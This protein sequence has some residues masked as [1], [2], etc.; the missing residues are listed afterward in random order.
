MFE[1]PRKW[2]YAPAL[3]QAGDSSKTEVE[4]DADAIARSPSPS[5]SKSPRSNKLGRNKSSSYRSPAKALFSAFGDALSGATRVDQEKKG[6]LG[7]H[8]QQVFEGTKRKP[9]V[10]APRMT[11]SL[12][13]KHA[14]SSGGAKETSDL[15]APSSCNLAF[16]F[17]EKIE[18]ECGVEQAGEQG[19]DEGRD[20]TEM[21]AH[22]RGTLMNENLSKTLGMM[23]IDPD[24]LKADQLFLRSLLRLDLSGNN[25]RRIENLDGVPQLQQL[26]LHS[27]EIE[28]MENLEHLHQLQKLELQYN[29]IAK[30][31]SI[32]GL[33]GL[34]FLNLEKNKLDARGLMLGS[35]GGAAGGGGR[36]ALGEGVILSSRNIMGVGG[37]KNM[38]SRAGSGAATPVGGATPTSVSRRGGSFS[39]AAS[40]TGA[41]DC[42]DETSTAA[43]NHPGSR[44]RG[45]TRSVFPVSLRELHLSHNKISNL[46]TS[47]HFL[48]NLEVLTLNHNRIQSGDIGETTSGGASCVSVTASRPSSA[49][50]ASSAAGDQHAPLASARSSAT[51]MSSHAATMQRPSRISELTASKAFL[52]LHRSLQNLPKLRELE[53]DSNRIGSLSFLTTTKLPGE[54]GVR[55]EG[56][57]EQGVDRKVLEPT[58]GI[59]AGRTSSTTSGR[60][61]STTASTST[62]FAAGAGNNAPVRVATMPSLMSLS[63]MSNFVSSLRVLEED[64][65]GGAAV[66]STA[67]A[68]HNKGHSQVD[69][70]AAPLPPKPPAGPGGAASPAPALGSS[71]HTQCK[72]A[73]IAISSLRELFLNNNSISEIAPNLGG[74]FTSLEALD[75]SGNP[76]KGPV[77]AVVQQLAANFGETLGELHI[78]VVQEGKNQDDE[79]PNREQITVAVENKACSPGLESRT[80]EASTNASSSSSTPIDGSTSKGSKLLNAAT[81]SS[82]S[83]VDP[84]FDAVLKE[85]S[86][87]KALAFLNDEPVPIGWRAAGRTGGGASGPSSAAFLDDSLTSLD[88]V[89]D[90]DDEVGGPGAGGAPRR[91]GQ[92]VLASDA[93]TGA[94]RDEGE[95]TGSLTLHLDEGQR[96]K[97]SDVSRQLQIMKVQQ[98]E[99][100]QEDGKTLVEKLVPSKRKFMREPELREWEVQQQDNLNAFQRH[101]HLLLHSSERELGRFDRAI[102]RHE[103]IIR[104]EEF[105]QGEKVQ[106]EVDRQRE[107]TDSGS[108]SSRGSAGNTAKIEES[109]AGTSI[110]GRPSKAAVNNY[111]GLGRRSKKITAKGPQ[112]SSSPSS[113]T[114]ERVLEE[115]WKETESVAEE[116]FAK[117]RI[118]FDL[119]TKGMEEVL[120]FIDPPW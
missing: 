118:D 84:A 81:N 10:V 6:E 30:V 67:A 75:L 68:G 15:P 106:A 80:T 44:N 31:A 93:A 23:K 43:S 54:L 91:D 113:A 108:R 29:R 86:R 4:N 76:I 40:A 120:L 25:I 12:M 66:A 115:D 77:E 32:D 35:G 5:R 65:A 95:D 89:L 61:S 28:V 85:S 27:C 71:S 104:R 3:R 101:M 87:W 11:L 82:N 36:A 52:P 18:M 110:G 2:T 72:D 9:G 99:Q 105:L 1:L 13:R 26:S 109:T 100:L 39:S 8:G 79:I 42:D 103:E 74:V 92:R 14:A 45:G 83:D 49:G 88:N 114:L 117:W 46:S 96:K 73:P 57:V 102:A 53:L 112:A 17:L 94:G 41:A 56:A 119:K 22:D 107:A 7:Q 97:A 78:K 58:K 116:Q 60:G 70:S 64:E 63:L 98:A 19:A 33:R 50:V 37:T 48:P 38:R 24:R 59:K 69:L 34:R 20:R 111:E 21:S 62:S 16:A 47:L 51:Q 55:L 90:D